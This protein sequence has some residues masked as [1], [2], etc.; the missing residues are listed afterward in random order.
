M[1][2]LVIIEESAGEIG[3]LQS[4]EA[5]TMS[6]G[7]SHDFLVF[8]AHKTHVSQIRNNS[9][10]KICQPNMDATPAQAANGTAFA[11]ASKELSNDERRF[12]PAN[13]ALG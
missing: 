8:D 6:I 7:H 5:V 2:I 10:G 11:K 13:R 3:H 9:E 4:G 12:P 1:E